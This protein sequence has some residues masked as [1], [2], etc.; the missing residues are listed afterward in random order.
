MPSVSRRRLAVSNLLRFAV[1]SLVEIAER[2]PNEPGAAQKVTL[3]AT[4][5]GTLGTAGDVD[6]YEFRARA[7]EEMVFQVVARPWDRDSTATSGCLTRRDSSSPP[8]TM[9]I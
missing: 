9:S 7:G 5:V 6:A 1:S 4:L 2:E 8:T 3:P